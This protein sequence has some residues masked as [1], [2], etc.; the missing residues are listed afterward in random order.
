MKN[1][2]KACLLNALIAVR[3]LGK[4]SV[5][6]RPHTEGKAE[7]VRGKVKTMP[8][9]KNLP[10]FIFHLKLQSVLWSTIHTKIMHVTKFSTRR[11]LK[12]LFVPWTI[13]IASYCLA[14]V[15]V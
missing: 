13:T 6:C 15:F 14:I 8:P 12:F 9:K 7:V 3:Y 2:E 5:R 4:E 1:E 10:P 11:S